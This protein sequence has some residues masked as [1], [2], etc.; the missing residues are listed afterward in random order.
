MCIDWHYSVLIE[1]GII[2]A[3][4]N[5]PG[6]GVTP[7]PLHESPMTQS[8]RDQCPSAYGTSD[9]QGDGPR[10]VHPVYYIEEQWRE[11]LSS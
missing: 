10:P 1:K 5:R 8:E 9:T 6:L 3:Y 2:K 11:H 4:G 7:H